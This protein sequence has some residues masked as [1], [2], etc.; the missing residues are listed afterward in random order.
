MT[1]RKKILVLAPYD[2]SHNI[3]GGQQ[4]CFN[5]YYGLAKKFDVIVLSHVWIGKFEVRIPIENLTEVILPASAQA[6]LAAKENMNWLESDSWD[7]QI[8][9]TRNLLETFQNY[10]NHYVK[11]VDLILLSHPWQSCFLLKSDLP[12]IY[13]AHNS[14]YSLFK[15]IFGDEAKSTKI[16]R[17]VEDYALQISDAV[18]ACTS[19]ELSGFAD[20]MPS[21]NDKILEIVRNGTNFPTHKFTATR[22]N[23]QI[24]FVGSAHLPNVTALERVLQIAVE[25]KNFRFDVVGDVCLTVN[26]KSVPSNVQ[27]HGRVTTGK[28]EELLS[29]SSIFINP[30]TEGGGSSLKIAQAISFGIPVVSTKFGLRGYLSTNSNETFY[31]IGE[32][33]SELI[34]KIK[35]ISSNPSLSKKLSNEAMLKSKDLE[36]NNLSIKLNEVLDQIKLHEKKAMY[37]DNGIA[38]I[39]S[40]VGL[41]NLDKIK[42]NLLEIWRKTPQPFRNF[43]TPKILKIIKRSRRKPHISIDQQIQS[44][45]QAF[46]TQIKEI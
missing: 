40:T 6:L 29:K 5:L 1:F 15:S 13:D 30:M 42:N 46:A 32:T 35:L 37:V 36:W 8:P 22:E 25:M 31:E 45:I 14:E 9:L 20:R 27:L 43:V 26:P 4:R 16:V 38:S 21:T 23:N 3:A 12:K 18:I 44:L 41:T 2:F 39:Q 17:I 19:D 28:L 33:N 34:E 24:I 10:V 7:I 11:E